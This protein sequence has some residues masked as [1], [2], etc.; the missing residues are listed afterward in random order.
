LAGD[1]GVVVLGNQ[2]EIVPVAAADHVDTLQ[3]R[4]MGQ[5][6]KIGLCR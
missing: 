5:Q 4:G 3:R 2:Q 1:L 6:R